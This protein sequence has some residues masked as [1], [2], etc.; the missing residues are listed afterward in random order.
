M[1]KV[2][3]LLLALSLVLGLPLAS[4]AADAEDPDVHIDAIDS[5]ALSA[6]ELSAGHQ[7]SIDG[8]VSFDDSTA[9]KLKTLTLV[10]QKLSGSSWSDVSGTTQ[11]S[12]A[13][14]GDLKVASATLADRSSIEGFEFDFDRTKITATG[15]Y[16]FLV[17]AVFEGDTTKTT[18]D[19]TARDTEKFD[20]TLDETP[21]RDLL[22]TDPAKVSVTQETLDAG[23]DTV[24]KGF[25]LYDADT[26]AEG[27]LDSLTV[28]VRALGG[29]WMTI[30]TDDFTTPKDSATLDRD[31]DGAKDDGTGYAFSYSFASDDIGMTAF[32][33]YQI[34]VTAAFTGDFDSESD[35]TEL[36]IAEK[37]TDSTDEDDDSDEDAGNGHGYGHGKGH[38]NGHAYGHDKNG[39]G[40]SN[41]AEP[42]NAAA[43]L[44]QMGIRHTFMAGPQ[45]ELKV[46]NFIACIARSAN[47]D[48]AF[49]YDWTNFDRDDMG[50]FFEAFAA[51]LEDELGVD[52]ELVQT[53]DGYDFY[54]NE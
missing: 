52:V 12:D 23:F 8:C 22:L 54:F 11:E 48:N 46:G 30:K 53:A 18:D 38:G 47:S 39:K 4:M 1:K 15:S 36:T 33:V 28:K 17:K 10:L 14:L 6:A 40:V 24:V 37:T 51:Y 25:V 50:D 20:V 43:W 16:R 26:N 32:G 2:L 3:S 41:R 35:T 13:T 27:R 49:S 19:I 5:Y 42:A 21:V 9:G 44:K 34:K 7:Q 29:S 31:G 45:G